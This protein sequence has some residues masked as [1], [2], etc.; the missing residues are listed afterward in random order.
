MS[1]IAVTNAELLGGLAIE[2]LLTATVGIWL[3]RSGWRPH[4]EA[5]LPLQSQD[6]AR[7]LGL[8]AGAILSVMGWA[9]VCRIL[10]PGLLAIAEQTQ[11]TGAPHF[12]VSVAFS[13]YNAL[14]EEL[15]W[16]ALGITAFRRFGIATAA[17]ISI[18]LRLL[19]HAYQGPLALVTILP[20]G[21][22][23]TVYY[24]RTRR[25]WPVVIAHAF[26]DVL[27]LSFLA[28]SAGRA[29]A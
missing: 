25:L 28:S 17:G 21:I 15:L 13:V 27:A 2:I 14:F 16:L 5:T 9:L 1:P 23:F 18:A 6:M 20:I 24:L 29:P 12:L 3:W 8:W 10:W 7:G 22:I 19:A 26:Q 4:R 11:I